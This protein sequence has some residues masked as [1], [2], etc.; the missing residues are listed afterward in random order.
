MQVTRFSSVD[1]VA[2][3]VWDCVVARSTT[4]TAFQLH[5]WQ[6]L[7]WEHFGAGHEP[8]I[9]V[10]YDDEQPIGIAPLAIRR[11]TTFPRRSAQVALA[12]APH[13][14]YADLIIGERSDEVLEAFVD[15]L[16]ENRKLWSSIELSN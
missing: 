3:A 5:V 15:W 7:W 2:P 14:N 13:G 6:R 16:L 11:T 4:A 12:G 9:L 8:L 1:A 10:A